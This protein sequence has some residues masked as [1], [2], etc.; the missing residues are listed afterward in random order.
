M[1]HCLAGPASQVVVV[2]AVVVVVVVVVVVEA[3]TRAIHPPRRLPGRRSQGSAMGMHSR[4]T[5]LAGAP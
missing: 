3:A 2:A 1:H 4:Q 5:D